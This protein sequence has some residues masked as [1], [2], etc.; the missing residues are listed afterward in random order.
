M[1]FIFIVIYW[2]IY[3]LR[4]NLMRELRLRES[5]ADNTKIT[6]GLI[7]RRLIVP[8]AVIALIITAITIILNEYS[9]VIL[10]T[11][12]Y[13]FSLISRRKI[14]EINLLDLQKEDNKNER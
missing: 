7:C 3:L 8:F 13:I 12:T 6:A 11:G 9:T 14:R 5:E 2:I 1:T 10:V 4:L